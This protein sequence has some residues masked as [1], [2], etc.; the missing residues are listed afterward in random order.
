LILDILHGDFVYTCYCMDSSND[1]MAAVDSCIEGPRGHRGEVAT[2]IKAIA[3]IADI[4]RR[5]VKPL[6]C[7]PKYDCEA[8]ARFTIF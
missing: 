6:C 4:I 3:A 7:H 1:G 8:L 5:I 2:A